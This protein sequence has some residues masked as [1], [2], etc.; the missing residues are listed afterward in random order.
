MLQFPDFFKEYLQGKTFSETER[1][2]TQ[3]GFVMND[4]A[5]TNFIYDVNRA[6]GAGRP[7]EGSDRILSMIL[8]RYHP[9]V[10]WQTLLR[11]HSDIISGAADVTRKPSPSDIAR[12]V[13]K[14]SGMGGP[15]R[16]ENR[17]LYSPEDMPRVEGWKADY[18]KRWPGKPAYGEIGLDEFLS[19]HPAGSFPN[20]EKLAHGG[21]ESLL[22]MIE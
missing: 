12:M 11:V 7:V 1:L 3:D 15:S 16:I 9:D 6:T 18:R 10:N 2:T 22:P 13:G 17:N 8:T 21:V 20:L 19:R 4:R 5:C 14:L